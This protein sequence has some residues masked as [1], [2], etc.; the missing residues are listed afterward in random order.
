VAAAAVLSNVGVKVAL[1][2][3]EGARVF[4]PVGV[5]VGGGSVGVRLGVGENAINGVRVGSGVLVIVGVSEGVSVN[6]ALGVNEGGMRVF[7]GV[8]VGVFVGGKVLVGVAVM[9]SVGD[10]GTVGLGV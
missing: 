4:V 10:G 3:K 7:V 6:V 2:V 5:M 8:M 1:G 9:N